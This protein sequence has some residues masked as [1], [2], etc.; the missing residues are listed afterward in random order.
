MMNNDFLRTL[1]DIV[2][3]VIGDDVNMINNAMP[4]R[5]ELDSAIKA[6]RAQQGDHMRRQQIHPDHEVAWAVNLLA[7]PAGMIDGGG[8]APP[9][10]RG[11]I[12]L[13]PV[14][15][16]AGGLCATC[17]GQILCPSNPN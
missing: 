12:C 11:C 4:I 6:A 16:F 17:G 15:S 9:V 10:I 7:S 1:A 2:L 3:R 14:V 5:D 13:P 8:G